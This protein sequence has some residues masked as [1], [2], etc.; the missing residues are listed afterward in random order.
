MAR[1]SLDGPTGASNDADSCF[2]PSAADLFLSFL[3]PGRRNFVSTISAATGVLLVHGLMEIYDSHLI[4]FN[5]PRISFFQ[6]VSF[7]S[8]FGFQGPNDPCDH[9]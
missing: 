7:A 1:R 3:H 8:P 2:L 5:V 6:T 9:N 4:G